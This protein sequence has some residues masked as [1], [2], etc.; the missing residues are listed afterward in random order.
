MAAAR[1]ERLIQALC[2]IHGWPRPVA[3]YRFSP[4]RRWRFDFAW[5][6]AH[7]ALEIDGG[8]WIR[9]RHVRPRGFLADLV[10][11]NE[12]AMLGWRV[13]R[14]P[15]AWIGT[16]ECVRWIAGCLTTTLTR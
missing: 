13:I 16:E 8:T 2:Q 11:L 7:V 9:G 15:P 10:K 12:A 14:V 5:P 6:G 4:T 1:Y 3:E